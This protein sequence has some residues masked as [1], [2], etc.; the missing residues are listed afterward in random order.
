[1]EWQ[2]QQ[3]ILNEL[4][5]TY[6]KYKLLYVTPEKIAR[7]FLEVWRSIFL[8]CYFKG[9]QLL[10]SLVVSA[11][12]S[13]EV[14]NLKIWYTS[15]RY[16]SKFDSRSDNLCRNLESIHKRGSLARIVIDE[17]HCVSQWGHD[18]RPDYQVTCVRPLQKFQ[19]CRKHIL[20]VHKEGICDD[21]T[22]T[23][24]FP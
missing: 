16:Y 15:N 13:K 8:S 3:Q 24:S 10:Q 2:E 7:Y 6:C 17:A 21:V 4:N 5:S 23:W 14:M 20:R 22:H 19:R 18:F 9:Q 12:P 1:M 11:V